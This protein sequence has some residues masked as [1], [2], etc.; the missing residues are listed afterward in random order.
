MDRAHGFHGCLQLSRVSFPEKLVTNFVDASAREPGA[1][2][3]AASK[4][5]DELTSLAGRKETSNDPTLEVNDV[6][7]LFK[8]DMELIRKELTT[9]LFY[10][11]Q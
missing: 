3:R 9:L 6:S 5:I 2:S 11:A 10:R 8:E 4:L 7:R 1:F